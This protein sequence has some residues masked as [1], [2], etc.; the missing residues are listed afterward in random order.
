MPTA[1]VAQNGAEIH[2]TTKIAVTGC[3]NAKKAKAKS[4]KE[5]EDGKE[6]H[7]RRLREGTPM[8]AKHT[9]RTL[10]LAAAVIAA[11][12]VMLAGATVAQAAP[13]ANKFVFSSHFGREVNLTETNAKAGLPLEDVCTVSSK[14]KCQPGTESSEPGGFSY[15]EGV[16]VDNDPASPEYGDVYVADRGN[17]RVQVLT[18]TGA[19]VSMFG[20]E[21]NRTKDEANASQ[22]ERNVCTAESKNVCQ[23]GVMGAAAGQFGASGPK[24]VAVDPA[25]GD[26]YVADLIFYSNGFGF[27]V[28]EFTA[29]GAWVLEIGKEVN[30]TTKGNLCTQEQVAK[31]DRCKGPEEHRSVPHMNGAANTARSISTTTVAVCWR[32]VALKTCCM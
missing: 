10:P 13:V 11:M 21:V 27:R 2:E 23:A 9:P 26:V 12:L 8:I 6:V 28:Q 17:H 30:E 22:A 25:N 14:D 15:A 7:Q 20:W 18:A 4:K 19:F 24:S 32:W 29:E 5:K 3:A 31:G 16:A 1:F